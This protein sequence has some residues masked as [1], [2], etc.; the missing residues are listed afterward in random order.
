MIGSL[1]GT[2]RSIESEV[3]LLDVHGV[4]YRIA[5]LPTLLAEVR[6]G[7]TL[8]LL[9]HLHVREDELA[10]YGFAVREELLFFRMLLD[11][12]GVGPKS[13]M[14]VLAVAL[15]EVLMRAISSGD[16]GLL[17]KVSGIGRKTAERIVVELKARL[18]REYPLLVGKGTTPHADAVE[19]LVSLGYTASQAREAIRRLPK[20]VASVEGVV[21]AALQAL[22]QRAPTVR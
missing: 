15:V 16:P 12:P 4:G 19:A 2:V 21:R 10:L 8:S 3:L 14:S 5:V 9:T 6:T 7:Q 18:E 17:T 1:E 20:D 22:G 13:A 11:V